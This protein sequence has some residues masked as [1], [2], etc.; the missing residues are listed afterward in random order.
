MCS[1]SGP[2]L[3]GDCG[4]SHAVASS[5]RWTRRIGVVALLLAVAFVALLLAFP[6]ADGED[7]SDECRAARD[8]AV[9]S[10]KFQRVQRLAE[11]R[12]VCGSTG[13]P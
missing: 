12:R 2:G 8:R 1:A 5:D 10:G 4:M 7:L 6:R 9:A 13:Q 3:R 11:M